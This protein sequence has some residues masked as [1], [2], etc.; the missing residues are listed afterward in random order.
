MTQTQLRTLKTTRLDH[1]VLH[2]NDMEKSKKFYCDL[3]GMTVYREREGHAFLKC[4]E[5]QFALF[6]ATD[7][8]K[9]QGY[10]EY[11]HIAITLESG[12]EE[13]VKAILREN[14]IDLLPRGEGL[15]WP[16]TPDIGVYIADPDGHR[17]QLLMPGER[18]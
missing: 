18:G 5:N 8:Q 2:V 16:P 10:T 13:E 9:A 3:L 11:D 12:T 14:G 6:E 17:I 4:G 7:G 1:I 15:G